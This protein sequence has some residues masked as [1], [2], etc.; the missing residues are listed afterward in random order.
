MTADHTGAPSPASVF[1]SGMTDWAAEGLLEGL[2]DDADRVAR[3]ELLDR[4]HTDGCS[5]DELRRAVAE[6]RLAL[7]PVERL[8]LK[9]R[10]WTKE[11]AVELTGLPLE[12]L[13]RDHLAMGLTFERGELAYTDE[14]IRALRAIKQMMDAGVTEREMLML[15]RMVGQ[16]SSRLA[17]AVLAT[18]GRVLLQPGVSERDLGVRLA[19]TAG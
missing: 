6:D 16:A 11:Q 19:D 8:L 4:L 17:D 10:R 18:L 5:I 2:D 13:E 15:T 9:D 12:Y 7:L 1:H 14:N 3:V